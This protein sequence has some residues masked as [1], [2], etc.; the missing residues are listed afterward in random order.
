MSLWRLF[1]L[2]REPTPSASREQKLS[3]LHCLY[4]VSAASGSVSGVEENEIRQIAGELNLRHEDYISVRLQ[5][6]DYLEV[7]GA[8]SSSEAGA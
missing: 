1:G 8:P 4:A 2:E 7:L 3:L 6:R 5:Y